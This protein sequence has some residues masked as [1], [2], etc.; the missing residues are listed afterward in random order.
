MNRTVMYRT[1]AI[2]IYEDLVSREFVNLEELK[3]NEG[4]GENDAQTSKLRI[5]VGMKRIKV[6]CLNFGGL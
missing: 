2:T 1:T 6:R 3:R 4:N 5:G